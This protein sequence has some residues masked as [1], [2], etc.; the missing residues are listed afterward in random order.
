MDRRL[1]LQGAMAFPLVGYAS[2]HTLDSNDI[3]VGPETW[4]LYDLNRHKFKDVWAVDDNTLK[5]Q[6]EPSTDQHLVFP[7]TLK[8][9]KPQKP[10]DFPKNRKRFLEKIKRENPDATIKKCVEFWYQDKQGLLV[11]YG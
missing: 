6:D 1:L 7:I 8:L 2:S 5:Y 3:K 11:Y 9:D 4:H 10:Q